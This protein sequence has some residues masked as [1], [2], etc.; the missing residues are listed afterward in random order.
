MLIFPPTRSLARRMLAAKLIGSIENFGVRSFE[1]TNAGRSATSY[2]S[3]VDP[4]APRSGEPAGEVIDES[5]IEEW[6]RDIRPEDFGGK[7]G[8]RE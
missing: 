8:D 7:P 5:E 1:A 2:G 4:E 6:T 3:F